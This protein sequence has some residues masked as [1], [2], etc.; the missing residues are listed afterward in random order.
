MTV[1]VDLCLLGIQAKLYDHKRAPFFH[2]ND[3]DKD[4]NS[5]ICNEKYSCPDW[6]TYISMASTFAPCRQTNAGNQII[7]RRLLD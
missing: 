1:S 3:V 6:N 7:I 4:T 2:E 5:L